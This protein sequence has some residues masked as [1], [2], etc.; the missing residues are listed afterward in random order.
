M[1]N[2]LNGYEAKDN[3]GY[4]TPGS[5]G[6]WAGI[7]R[8][9]PMI[10][11]ELPRKMGGEEAWEQNRQALPVFASMFLCSAAAVPWSCA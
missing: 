6:S 9:I 5:L 7:D 10:T 2:G 8:Q 3:I 11:L 4:P 1:A